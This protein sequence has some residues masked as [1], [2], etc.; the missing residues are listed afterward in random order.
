MKKPR[1]NHIAIAVNDIEHQSK[2]FA[3]IFGVGASQPLDLPS[4]GVRVV[5][6]EFENIMIE[7]IAPLDNAANINKF[8]QKKGEGLHHLCIATEDIAATIRELAEKKIELIDS[9]PRPGAHGK[10]VAFLHP[11]ST[12]SVLIELEED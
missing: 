10:P 8:L 7:L 12:G 3:D 5:F 9:E 4:Q 11:K 2:L 1:I 6:L